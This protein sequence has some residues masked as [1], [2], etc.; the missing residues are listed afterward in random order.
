MTSLI[1]VAAS[2]LARE[3]IAVE[4]ASGRY[5][6]LM[7]VDDDRALWGTLVDGVRVVGPVV[8]AAEHD[9]DL[10]LCAGR[11]AVRR[12]LAHRLTALGV[13]GRRYGRVIHPGVEIPPGCTVGPGCIL[14][15]SVVMTAGV[16]LHRHVVAMPHVT[17]THDDVVSDFATLCAKVAL[18]GGVTV[19][20]G[21]Y[22]GMS[23]SVRENVVVGADAVLGM[24]SVLL[25]NLPAGETWAGV[26]AQSLALRKQ[27]VP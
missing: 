1:L 13:P 22:L 18:G 8:A 27:L 5:D 24:G 2:G 26:P 21:A 3:V 11:G 25:R 16:H 15:A 17:L 19:G 12:H 23:S 6:E 10:V 20:E 7:L 9:G 14:L 4:A